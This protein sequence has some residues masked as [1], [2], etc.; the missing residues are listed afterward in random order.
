M[1]S[2]ESEEWRMEVE[3]GE[4][5]GEWRVKR[6][7]FRSGIGSSTVQ[8]ALEVESTSVA[9]PHPGSSSLSRKMVTVYILIVLGNGHRREVAPSRRDTTPD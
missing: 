5:S 9:P 3:S 1:W 6:G 2:V 4:W 8:G 7:D